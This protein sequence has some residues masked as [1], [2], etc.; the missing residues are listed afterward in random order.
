MSVRHFFNKYKYFLTQKSEWKMREDSLTVGSAADSE[1]LDGP[2]IPAFVQ[3]GRKWCP[4]RRA[5]IL[6]GQS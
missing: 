4:L 3:D 6:K 5:S 1:L 2:T